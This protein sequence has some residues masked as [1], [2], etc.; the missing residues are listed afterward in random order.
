MVTPVSAT[1]LRGTASSTIRYGDWNISVPQVP[2][3][4]GLGETVEL[5]LD[6]LAT[7]TA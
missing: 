5:R 6:F 3:V 7:A 1:E 4:A 2:S